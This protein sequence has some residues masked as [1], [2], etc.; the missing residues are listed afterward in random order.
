LL[1]GNTVP[2][3]RVG[4]PAAVSA[5]VAVAR[6]SFFSSE[7]QCMKPPSGYPLYLLP[8]MPVFKPTPIPQKDAAVIPH[9]SALNQFLG[10]NNDVG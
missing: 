8:R 6:S 4:V 9:A 5:A 2:F 7:N 10:K 3:A 1:K